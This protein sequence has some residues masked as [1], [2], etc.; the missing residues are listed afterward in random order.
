M[1]DR[2]HRYARALIAIAVVT[3]SEML[4]APIENDPVFRN[5]PVLAKVSRALLGGTRRSAEAAAVGYRTAAGRPE[6]D[7]RLSRL[8]PAVLERARA[9]GLEILHSD[10]RFARILGYCPGDCLPAL[11]RMSEVTAIHPNYGARTMTGSVLSQADVS[12]RADQARATYDVSGEGVRIGMISDTLTDRTTGTFAGEGCNRTFASN[13]SSASE[14]PELVNVIAEPDDLGVNHPGIDEG[15][16]MAELIH[17]LAP[18]ATLFFHTAFTTQSIFAHAIEVLVDCGVDIIVDDVIYFSEPMFQDGIIAQAAADAASQG[19]AFFSAIGN[20]GIGGIDE[21]F[22]D[23]NPDKDDMPDTPSGADL[24]LFGNGST[25]APVQIPRGCG[26]RMIL[27][28]N[29]P[30]SG[31]LGDGASSDLDLY[32]CPSDNPLTCQSSN[33]S[34]DSQGCSARGGGRPSG[35]PIEILDVTNFSANDRTFYVAVEHVCGSKDLRFRVVS[36]ALSCNFPDRYEF[37]P[38]AYNKS[39]AYGH[40]IGDGVIGTA[41]VFYQEIDSEGAAEG[42]PEVINVEGFSSLGG[43]LP[44]YFDRAGEPLPSGPVIRTNPLIAAPDG[45][46]TSFFG[47]RDEE[48][49]GFPNFFGTS[50]AAPHAAAVAALML[51]A[52]PNITSAQILQLLQQT[53]IDIE[54]P[55][56]DFLSGSGL[57]DAVDAVAAAGQAPALS[58]TPTP[59]PPPTPTNTPVAPTST[60]PASPSPT[61]CPGDCDR[62]GSVTIDEL[63][64]AVRINLGIASIDECIASDLDVD[65]RITVS[66]LIRSIKANLDGCQAV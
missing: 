31:V 6:L 12:I 54:A 27:Q 61:V 4:A 49:D 44:I 3:A 63:M 56:F 10:F 8:T 62:D 9:T 34:R 39:Q 37:D 60:A 21:S 43:E 53:S 57:I 42:D 2:R 15:R 40:P 24:H 26:L 50:A 33:G 7:V 65:G 59:T 35:D 32:A 16:A 46:N 14:L 45:T 64:R 66:E 17:D 19:V 55:G 30:F 1:D 47:P 48:N 5:D 20:L 13:A 11:A 41:A 36:F 28:W 22:R 18:G 23:S 25:F 51:E 38:V 52:N 29:E 58:P